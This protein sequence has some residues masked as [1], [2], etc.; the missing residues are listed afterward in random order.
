MSEHERLWR[1]VYYPI[2]AACLAACLISLLDMSWWSPVFAG[3][4]FGCFEAAET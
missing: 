3:I 1:L 4:A 2:C